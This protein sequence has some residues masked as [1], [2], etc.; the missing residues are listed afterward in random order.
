MNA[1]KAYVTPRND[2]NKWFPSE[3]L[4]GGEDEIDTAK[5]TSSITSEEI[6]EDDDSDY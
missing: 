2:N 6:D 4:E 5:D 1:Y 3:L